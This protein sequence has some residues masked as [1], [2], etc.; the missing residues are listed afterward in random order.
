M[1]GVPEVFNPSSI[2][3]ANPNVMY[4]RD[5]ERDMRPLLTIER[6]LSGSQVGLGTLLLWLDLLFEN[7]NNERL[8]FW[9]QDHKD[10]S[11]YVWKKWIYQGSF[12]SRTSQISLTLI[13]RLGPQN[14]GKGC[15][16]DRMSKQRRIR[17]CHGGAHARTDAYPASP[18]PNIDSR[19]G[20]A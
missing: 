11:P 19:K 8:M 10:H 18:W 17:W 20:P 9:L 5:F 15:S 4:Q 6:Y 13:L 14:I 1:T 3:T 2:T 16:I 7:N 12:H